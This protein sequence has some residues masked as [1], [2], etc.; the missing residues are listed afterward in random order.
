M[1]EKFGICQFI[2]VILVS[3]A[4]YHCRGVLELVI[5]LYDMCLLLRG[6]VDLALVALTS[7]VAIPLVL[8]AFTL[9]HIIAVALWESFI[10]MNCR[11]CSLCVVVFVFVFICNRFVTNTVES[12]ETTKILFVQLEETKCVP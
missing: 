5:E 4:I 12:P 10:E 8:A 3:E 6:L 1:L 9:I 2:L 11:Q 7:I